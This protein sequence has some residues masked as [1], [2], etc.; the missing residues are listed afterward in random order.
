MRYI[1]VARN[2][3]VSELSICFVGVED[4]W[5]NPVCAN[6]LLIHTLFYVRDMLNLRDMRCTNSPKCVSWTL[7]ENFQTSC[8]FY[9]NLGQMLGSHYYRSCPCSLLS[10]VPSLKKKTPKK[11]LPT[12]FS[13][14]FQVYGRHHT[15]KEPSCFLVSLSR[16]CTFLLVQSSWSVR[17]T[18]LVISGSAANAMAFLYYPQT[19]HL[20]TLHW[21]WRSMCLLPR[22]W[23]PEIVNLF[24]HFRD[25][26]FL[27]SPLC[28]SAPEAILCR[29]VGKQQCY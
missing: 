29:E 23:L 1:I 4:T 3:S 14:Y 5:L 15:E 24:P 22:S 8:Y 7:M 12:S 18:R 19:A 25:M 27:S 28:S 10:T 11:R 6:C 16:Y 9:R 17:C 2:K 20:K 26:Y 21:E 13:I